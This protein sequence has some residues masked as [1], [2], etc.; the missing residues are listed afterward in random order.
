MYINITIIPPI[1]K[2]VTTKNAHE[3]LLTPKTHL[4]K[5]AEKIRLPM[6]VYG[7][8]VSPVIREPTIKK[9]THINLY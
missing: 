7:E 2:I 5:K 8:L 6:A 4:T 9:Y 1:N 3:I